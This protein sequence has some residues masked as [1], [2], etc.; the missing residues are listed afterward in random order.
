MAWIVVYSKK[1]E[2]QYKNLPSV[3]QDRLDLLTAEIE[4]LGPIRH[5]WKNYS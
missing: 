1:A 5:N 3:V 4:L 2:K